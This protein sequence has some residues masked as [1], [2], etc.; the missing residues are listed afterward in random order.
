MHQTMTA[1]YSD[2]L[3]D[4][5]GTDLCSFEVC[6]MVLRCTDSDIEY[7]AIHAYSAVHSQWLTIE[8][9]RAKTLPY[10]GQQSN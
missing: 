9:M 1:V 7:S 2:P 10:K 6:S 8:Y 5:F 4:K 3:G